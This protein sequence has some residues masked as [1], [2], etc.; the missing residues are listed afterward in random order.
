MNT[1]FIGHDPRQPISTNVLTQ[2]IHR[3]SSKPVAVVPLILEQLPITNRGLTPFTYS[4]FLVPYLT[5]FHGSAVFMDCDFICLDDISHLF[6]CR[7]PEY[8]VQI[9]EGDDWADRGLMFERASM[10][11]FNCDHPDNKKLTPTYVQAKQGT[12]IDWTDKIG[13]LPKKWN[14]LV[15]YDAKHPKEIGLVHYTQGVPAYLETEGCEF[16]HAWKEEQKLMNFTQPWVNLMGN[17]V[18]A[19]SLPNG[20]KIPRF[21][22]EQ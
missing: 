17:S 14:H 10:M 22:V 16:S 18:H 8:A 21:Q 19:V 12:Q 1:V 5:G 20:R 7:D 9:V 6:G 11:L 15:G 13:K 4:R 3:R 2:S